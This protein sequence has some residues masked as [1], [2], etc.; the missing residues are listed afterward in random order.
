M[1]S[2]YDYVC[3][4]NNSLTDQQF[5]NILKRKCF[6]CNSLNNNHLGIDRIDSCDDYHVNNVVPCCS[7]C[8][9]IKS[10][11]DID[12]FFNQVKNILLNNKINIQEKTLIIENKQNIYLTPNGITKIINEYVD[13]FYKNDKTIV[14]N[15]YLQK[16]ELYINEIYNEK[17][18]IEDFQPELIICQT[19][20][21]CDKWNYYKDHYLSYSIDIPDEP[22]TFT[23]KDQ[24][25][26]NIKILV[27][28]KKTSKYAGIICLSPYSDNETV[29]KYIGWGKENKYDPSKRATVMILSV[30]AGLSK[31]S[32]N[33][34]TCK[35]FAMLIQSKEF[36]ELYTTIFKKQLLA[37]VCHSK[38]GSS[39]IFNGLK[40]Y[41]FLGEHVTYLNYSH[42]LPNKMIKLSEKYIKANGLFKD[43]RFE[44]ENEQFK[45]L[46]GYLGIKNV[47]THGYRSGI[48]ISFLD[49]RNTIS[50]F[51]TNKIDGVNVNLTSSEDIIKKWY[52]LAHK[53]YL[54]LSKRCDDQHKIIENNV[55]T[56]DSK[57]NIYTK[58]TNEINK[59]K[60]PV[61]KMLEN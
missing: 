57:I 30:C 18:K 34:A 1:F 15:E 49:N 45:S 52:P 38:Y 29:D 55:L 50:D 33:Y 37:I 10:D 26:K 40:N 19:L 14:K 20:D 25:I 16:D 58:Y 28:D 9:R 12:V 36:I 22:I 3:F 5:N 42:K 35:L 47:A 51:L 39:A 54:R 32:Y 7:V 61:K 59:Q 2:K 46:C 11:H 41:K 53:R 17:N 56:N 27:K 6:Y 24:D 13:E 43:V 23:S 4:R 31:L 44:N 8:N 48:Y 60:N 21:L